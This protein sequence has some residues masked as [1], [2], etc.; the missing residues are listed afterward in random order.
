MGSVVSDRIKWFFGFFRGA[1]FGRRPSDQGAR[2]LPGWRTFAGACGARGAGRDKR[3]RG[4]WWPDTGCPELQDLDLAP[5]FLADWCD[6]PSIGFTRKRGGVSLS[7]GPSREF[8]Y[9]PEVGSG[10]T[11]VVGLL[12][13][14]VTLV[15]HVQ[16]SHPVAPSPV[17]HCPGSLHAVWRLELS[18][19]V[20]IGAQAGECRGLP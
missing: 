18:G 9:P 13:Q 5:G 20:F 14:A 12:T 2:G 15:R 10:A 3:G 7:H 1:V 16:I 8:E 11:G 19:K 17:C 4:G 6:A